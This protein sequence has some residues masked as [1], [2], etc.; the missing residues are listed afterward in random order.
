MAVAGNNLKQPDKQ[1]LASACVVQPFVMTVG[2]L[3]V[4]SLFASFF[5]DRADAKSDQCEL[6]PIY[7]S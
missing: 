7:C 1:K 5:P 6:G 2:I 4:M 3:G